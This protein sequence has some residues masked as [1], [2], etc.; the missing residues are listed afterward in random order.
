MQDEPCMSSGDVNPSMVDAASRSDPKVDHFL[1]CS[2]QSEVLPM[3]DTLVKEAQIGYPF[4]LS[5]NPLHAI[6]VGELFCT[7]S[8]ARWLTTD[9]A[10]DFFD[11]LAVNQRLESSWLQS[12][13]LILELSDNI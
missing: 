1:A 4:P 3:I 5:S 13:C 6:L 8:S 12:V 2:R 7:S 11:A 9:L 10:F